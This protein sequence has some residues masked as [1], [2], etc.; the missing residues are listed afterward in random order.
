MTDPA[1]SFQHYEVLRREDGTAW[2]LGRGAMGVTYK[3]F[4]VN[5]CC[6]VA[7]KVVSN[8]LVE[9]PEAR[10]R[11]VREARAAAALRHR[12]V[13]SVYHLGN[14]GEHFFYAMEFINGETLDALVRR[15]GPLTVTD[16]LRVAL[17]VARALAAAARQRLVHRD[18]KPANLMVTHEDADEETVVKVIDFGLARAAADAENAPPLTIGGFVGTPQFASPEQLEERPLDARSDLYSLGVTTWFLLTGRVPFS[19]SLATIC[20]Q[21]LGQSPPW[22]HLPAQLPPGVRTLLERLLEKDPARRPQTAVEL[23]AE[24]ETCLDHVQGATRDRHL[25]LSAPPLPVPATSPSKPNGRVLRTGA[26]LNGRYRLLREVGDKRDLPVYQARDESNAERIVAVKVLPSGRGDWQDEVRLAQAATHHNLAQIFALERSPA[27]DAVFLVEEWL[28]GFTLRDLLA[29]RGGA[30]PVSEA[31][32]LL[33][34]AAQVCDHAQRCRLEP[35]DLATARWHVC[36]LS[37]GTLADRNLHGRALLPL[38]MAEW[39]EWTLKTHAFRLREHPLALDT[40]AGGDTLLPKAKPGSKTMD[41]SGNDYA[42]GLA[43]LIHELLGGRPLRGSSPGG[44]RPGVLPA[45]NEESNLL[46]HRTLSGE[47]TFTSGWEWFEA[48]SRAVGGEPARGEIATPAAKSLPP[49]PDPPVR[50]RTL[51]ASTSTV[52]GRSSAGPRELDEPV[53]GSAWDRLTLVAPRRSSPARWAAGLV[54]LTVVFVLGFVGLFAWLWQQPAPRSRAASPVKTRSPALMAAVAIPSPTAH[55]IAAQAAAAWTASTAARSSPPIEGAPVPS[56]T[57]GAREENIPR[58]PA[59]PGSTSPAPAQSPPRDRL[60]TVR[61]DSVPPGAQIRLGNEVLGITPCR[62]RLS[63][64]EHQLIARFP[65]WP[66]TRQ[67]IHLD[68]TEPR[69]SVEIRLMRPDLI[70]GAAS[71]SP[72]TVAN[73]VRRIFAPSVPHPIASA[74]ESPLP[75]SAEAPVRPAQPV[76][77]PF[78]LDEPE[79]ASPLPDASPATTQPFTADDAGDN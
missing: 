48:F 11:F 50:E 77:T 37:A 22:A 33:E 28:T 29:G 23:R 63:P 17:Q 79:A 71:P 7:L 26:L 40:W 44:V 55:P 30:L 3:A 65:G 70:P 34:P 66:E 59:L 19:G 57:A 61:L 62:V 25:R 68:G 21:Q 51:A 13:A 69:V 49:P 18:I 38:S 76:L 39:P 36:F 6:E 10:E 52:H 42:R 12:N 1:R 64:G 46:L 78:R 43:G 73:R 20:Q 60:T 16:T 14:D 45:L 31:L 47:A 75:A 56:P 41:A 74:G 54:G 2:E 35:L 24:I 58:L 4:D 8:A 67:S 9:H 32:R 27:P 15:A 5:L 72:P 53:A